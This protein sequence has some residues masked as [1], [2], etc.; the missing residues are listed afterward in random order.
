[1]FYKIPIIYGNKR[2]VPPELLPV[3]QAEERRPLFLKLKFVL[4]NCKSALHLGGGRV[5]TGLQS[6]KYQH[7]T[8]CCEERCAMLGLTFKELR[9]I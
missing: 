7:I 8:W 4:R 1:M 9:R 6:V 5:T 3:T 2:F